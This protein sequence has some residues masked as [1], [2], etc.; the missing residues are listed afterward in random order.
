MKKTTKA[1]R[2]IRK[3]A[4]RAQMMP[5]LSC[6]RNPAGVPGDMINKLSKEDRELLKEL[7]SEDVE[8]V[9]VPD[10]W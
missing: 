7:R 1:A 5:I 9:M 10:W 3:L 4:E 6:T 8:N 2:L